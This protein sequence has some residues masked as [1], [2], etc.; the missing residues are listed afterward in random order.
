MIKHLSKWLESV[1]LL[2]HT[3]EGA[4]YAF[5]DIMFIRF[6]V[7]VEVFINQGTITTLTSSL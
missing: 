5:L 7:P 1:P 6:G 3:S 2:D 4:T